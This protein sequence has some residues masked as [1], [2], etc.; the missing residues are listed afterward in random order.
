MSQIISNT[1]PSDA[2]DK[3]GYISC[4][5]KLLGHD[6]VSS[7]HRAIDFMIARE[8]DYVTVESFNSRFAS[9]P[10]IKDIY[11]LL[12]RHIEDD[13][14]RQ[15]FEKLYIS[16]MEYERFMDLIDGHPSDITLDSLTHVLTRYDNSMSI[17][18]RCKYVP[19]RYLIVAEILKRLRYSHAIVFDAIRNVAQTRE[20]YHH[21][22][23]IFAAVMIDSSRESVYEIGYVMCYNSCEDLGTLDEY[24]DEMMGIKATLKRSGL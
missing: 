21:E 24:Y 15:F 22:L 14:D 8:G 17:A 7:A 6:Q 13:G 2:D 19:V 11:D 16:C 5:H 3:C 23:P 20:F 12:P 18:V 4:P 9:F 10:T 1:P